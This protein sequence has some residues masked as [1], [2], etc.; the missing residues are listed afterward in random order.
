MAPDP[1][2]LVWEEVTPAK[3]TEVWVE[4]IEQKA[5]PKKARFKNKPPG[6]VWEPCP[7]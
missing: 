7:W 2:R 5:C 1:S 4:K 6:D 3:R